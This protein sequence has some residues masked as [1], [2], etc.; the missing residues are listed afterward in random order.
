MM[1]FS[2]KLAHHAN[3]MGSTC[4]SRRL[5]GFYLP[6]QSMDGGAG[7]DKVTIVNVIFLLWHEGMP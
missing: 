4:S 2:L 1:P 5:D 6:F 3:E 7:Q